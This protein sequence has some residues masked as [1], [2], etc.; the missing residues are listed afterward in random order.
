MYEIVYGAGTMFFLI[1]GLC[2]WF[3]SLIGDMEEGWKIK[4]IITGLAMLAIGGGL[5]EGIFPFFPPPESY[6]R[7]TIFDGKTLVKGDGPN[8]KEIVVPEKKVEMR[9]TTDKKKVGKFEYDFGWIKWE[10][11]TEDIKRI[12]TIRKGN[13]Y[14][15]T[16]KGKVKKMKVEFYN[17]YKK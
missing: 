10:P 11:T 8:G 15:L 4:M 17:K 14:Y 9:F 3:S 13:V 2:V 5:W 7:I 1:G 12:L 6:S 16:K